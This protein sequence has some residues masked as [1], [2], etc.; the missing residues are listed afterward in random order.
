MSYIL[1]A[2]KRSEQ[3]RQRGAAPSLVA[4][5]V[6]DAAPREPAV[7][8][9]GLAAAALLVVGIAVGML[10]PWRTNAPALQSVAVQ[11]PA[12]VVPPGP[13]APAPAAVEITI[14]TERPTPAL[15]PVTPPALSA[16]ADRPKPQVPAPAAPAQGIPAKSA[17][18][19]ESRG[20]PPAPER[21]A[22]VRPLDAAPER[23]PI[24][25]A[26]LPA[27]IQQD[28]PKLSILFHIYSGNPKDRLVGIN[29]LV[30]REGDS[31]EPGLV[32]EQITADGMI[33]TYKGYRFL[34]GPR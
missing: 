3:Q 19:P 9:Y 16:A 14:R 21:P 26:E 27:S 15:A 11:S 4:A 12:V 7:L 20:L 29:N 1:D 28:V 8:L 13:P 33:L 34:R 24:L 23:T 6:T 10:R 31:V 30:L 2:L 17:N 25:F 22:G 32:L 5:Q 18:A